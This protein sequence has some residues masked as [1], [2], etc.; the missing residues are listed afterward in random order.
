MAKTR[1]RK[2]ASMTVPVAVIAGFAPFAMHLAQ[3][4]KDA[5]LKG[6]ANNA[7]LDT[8][9]YYPL[10]NRFD[11]KWPIAKFYGPVLAGL[12]VHKLAGK[13]GVNRTLARA[14]VPFLR[15]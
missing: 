11:M 8:T 4:Y 13:L 1:R 15:V 5:G 7:V 14:G 6:V 12:L 3:G 2:A 10:E 9:G